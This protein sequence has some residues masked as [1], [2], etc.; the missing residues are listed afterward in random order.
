LKDL[1]EG[2]EGSGVGE[3][4]LRVEERAVLS[5]QAGVHRGL[6][7]GQAGQVRIDRVDGKSSKGVVHCSLLDLTNCSEPARFFLH[8]SKVEPG[9][10]N[11]DAIV[12]PA[13]STAEIPVSREEGAGTRAARDGGGKDEGADHVEDDEHEDDHG[14]GGQTHTIEG[15]RQKLI[16]EGGERC[17][18]K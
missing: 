2:G 6:V 17:R 8:S 14:H 9:L 16:G 4:A 10:H 12:N 3:R 11:V 5:T 13:S 1:E 15:S 18:A 7:L